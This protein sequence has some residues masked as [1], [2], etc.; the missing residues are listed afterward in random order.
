T[1]ALLGRYEQVAKPCRLIGR[2][3][4]ASYIDGHEVAI[5]DADATEWSRN[6][7]PVPALEAPTRARARPDR[8]DRRARPL[9]YQ[10]GTRR[11]RAR[12]TARSVGG[13]GEIVSLVDHTTEPEERTRR[14][15]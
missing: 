14:A 9:R 11:E 5:G 7:K 2:I 8:Q 4:R 3:T 1:R 6:E 10:E 13:D 12:G 15:T